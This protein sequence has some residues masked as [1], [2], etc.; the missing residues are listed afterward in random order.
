MANYFSDGIAD[1][2]FLA[3]AD[4]TAQQF[5]LVKASSSSGYVQ[6]FA[7]ETIG[8]GSPLAIGILTNDPSAGQEAAVKC[9]GFTKALGRVAVCDLAHGAW[10]T[11]ASDGLVE[12][13]SAVDGTDHVIGRWFGPRVTTADASVYGNVLIFVTSTC[14]GTDSV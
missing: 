8:S 9:I 13:C 11:G 5:K 10:L 3:D 1:V 14:L 7:S 12:A 6:A 4:L 2:P